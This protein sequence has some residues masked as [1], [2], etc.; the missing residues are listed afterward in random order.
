L[1]VWFVD[2]GVVLGSE[3]PDDENHAAA[4]QLLRG[5]A[6]SSVEVG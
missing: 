2:A 5:D 6:P 3:D 1:T 4:G